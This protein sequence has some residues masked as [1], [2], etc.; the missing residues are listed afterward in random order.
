M[1]VGRVKVRTLRLGLGAALAVLALVSAF[2]REWLRAAATTMT[3]IPMA[4]K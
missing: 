2:N 4:R 1:R 3:T